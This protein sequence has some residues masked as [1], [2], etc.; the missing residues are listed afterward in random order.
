MYCFMLGN[1]HVNQFHTNKGDIINL[2][3]HQ[4]QMFERQTFMCNHWQKEST[5]KNILAN[6]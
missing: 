1:C 2:L 5:V 6:A 4:V 3:F